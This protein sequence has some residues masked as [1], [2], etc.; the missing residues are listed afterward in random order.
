M[1]PKIYSAS[2]TKLQKS[3]SSVTKMAAEDNN[4]DGQ[5]GPASKKVKITHD[6][7]NG[8]VQDNGLGHIESGSAPASAPERRRGMAPIKAE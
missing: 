4:M 8:A 5:D 2:A 7:D 1:V 3:H 6:V